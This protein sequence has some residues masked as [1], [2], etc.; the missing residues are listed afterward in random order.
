MGPQ[1]VPSVARPGMAGRT[2]GQNISQVARRRIEAL[3][4][5]FIDRRAFI[6]RRTA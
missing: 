5:A 1:P 4:S 6:Q 2:E 3:S